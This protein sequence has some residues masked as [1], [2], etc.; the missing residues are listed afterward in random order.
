M[1]RVEKDKLFFKEAK[2]QISILKKQNAKM[3][4]GLKVIRD[5]FW[6][7]P[8]E[9]KKHIELQDI[10]KSTLKELES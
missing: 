3:L 1:N 4:E 9:S 5:S 7:E 6:T 10:A 8:S 2:R